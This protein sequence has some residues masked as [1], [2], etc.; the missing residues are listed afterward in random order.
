MKILSQ[1]VTFYQTVEVD[2]RYGIKKVEL[3]F[4]FNL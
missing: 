3:L 4:K 1:L 2:M